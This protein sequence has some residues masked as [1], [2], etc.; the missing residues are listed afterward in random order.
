MVDS[1]ALLSEMVC[2]I[3]LLCCI[4]F[5]VKVEI[6]SQAQFH[7]GRND[8]RKSKQKVDIK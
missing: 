4:S 8:R 2:N 6:Q 3:V 7:M 5:G 1:I